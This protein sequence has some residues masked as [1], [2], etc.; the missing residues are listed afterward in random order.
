MYV[1]MY[2]VQ[3]KRSAAGARISICVDSNICPHKHSY[4]IQVCMYVCMYVCMHVVLYY[5]CMYVGAF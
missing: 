4:N 2:V 3:V 1:C 5:V